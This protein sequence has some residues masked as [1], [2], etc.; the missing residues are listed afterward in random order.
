MTVW[1]AWEAPRGHQ[2]GRK[3]AFGQAREQ[4]GTREERTISTAWAA[5][6]RH[7]GGR[8]GLIGQPGRHQGGT[9]EAGKDELDSLRS[10]REAPGGQ[11]RTT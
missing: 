9:R 2:G 10:S 4:G 3:G 7:Q 8:E 11:E 6:G 1:T 5:P